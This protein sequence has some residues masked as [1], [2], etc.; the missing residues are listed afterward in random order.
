[1]PPTELS[2]D[3]ITELGLP[4]YVYGDVLAYV[5]K[6]HT[7]VKTADENIDKARYN[8]RLAQVTPVPDLT[9]SVGGFYDNNQTG[10]PGS[11]FRWVTTFGLGFTIPVWDQNKGAVRQMQG[12]LVQ[13][14]EEPHRV[15]NAL[16]ASLADAFQRYD[17][18]RTFLQM[19][20]KEILPKQ[21]QALRAAVLRYET[22]VSEIGPWDI[23][24]AEQNLV[25]TI[26]SY[27][28]ILGGTWQAIVDVAS[29][30]QTDDIFQLA[31]KIE[32]YAM[33]DLVEL[34][35]CCHPCSPLQN[36][37]LK[38]ID[39]I[40]PPT[41]NDVLRPLV[42]LKVPEK[43]VMDTTQSSMVPQETRPALHLE[44]GTAIPMDE[45]RSQP[46]LSNPTAP[47][48]QIGPSAAPAAR[49]TGNGQYPGYGRD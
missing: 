38:T 37:R 25:G 3:R 34:L 49:N 23:V 17:S 22:T 35:H 9:A 15:R 32:P 46:Q 13:M 36:P 19:Y 16:T 27:L 24:A 8:L 41:A 29:L 5:L 42:P 20:K 2:P 18:N 10:P 44:F 45:P 21:V 1:M 30:L 26:G 43:K 47:E 7:D 28:P 40:Y 31:T 6:N 33:V 11:G 48:V 39:P 12:N 14:M 4:H